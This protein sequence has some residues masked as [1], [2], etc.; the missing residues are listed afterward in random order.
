MSNLPILVLQMQRM[1]DLVLSFP[2]LARLRGQYPDNP[3]WVTGEELFFKPLMELSPTATYFNYQNAPVAPGLKFHLVV[4]LS[5]RPEAAALAGKAEAEELVG[6]YL[7]KEGALRI[8]GDYQLYRAS[9]T[10]NNHLNRFHWADLNSLDV[11]PAKRMQYTVWPKPKNPD[12]ARIREGARIGLFLGASEPAKH[13]DAAFWTSLTKMLLAEGHK[14]A[15]LGGETE[16]P[17]GNEVAS[18]LRA[19][20]LN[21]CG[22]FNVEELAKFLGGLD[23]LITPDTG[24]MHV[25]VWSGTPVLNISVGPVHVWET[26]PFAPGHHALRAG[27]ECVGCWR[28]TRP[29]MDCRELLSPGKTARI[30]L[31]LLHGRV[32]TPDRAAGC[33]LLQSGRDHLGRYALQSL[34]GA[35]A[36]RD[37]FS[38]FW[39]NFFTTLFRAG[40]AGSVNQAF[41]V[42]AAEHPGAAEAF[43]LA[44]RNLVVDA[45]KRLK[46]GGGMLGDDADW[47]RGFAPETR[48]LAG[49]LH[50]LV[51]NSDDVP[52]R[53]FEALELLMAAW[54]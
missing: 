40:D 28:C 18:A 45:A 24:P 7:D 43:A 17:L 51:Q 6:P 54:A 52:R 21:L 33:E 22:R 47:W 44:G 26:G 49:Y 10:H 46:K 1:G 23:L 30:A 53:A 27:I 20:P 19:H 41:A 39:Q 14:P 9:L 36:L 4:N 12:P 35:D 29:H 2:L 11:I 5:H 15:L 8:R 50:M 38:V 3:I 25:A 34:F 16:K 32:P 13:P 48:P 37:N 31:D 42:L